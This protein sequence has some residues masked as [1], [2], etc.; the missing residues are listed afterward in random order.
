MQ[1]L[2]FY[3][4]AVN[5]IMKN[6]KV[7]L[8]SGAIIVAPEKNCLSHVEK[9]EIVDCRLVNTAATNP[10]SPSTVYVEF[11]LN[12]MKDFLIDHYELSYTL[13]NNDTNTANLVCAPYQF[14]KVEYYKDGNTLSDPIMA[15]TI[16]IENM[17]NQ[18]QTGRAIYNTNLGLSNS[19]GAYNSN[20]TIAAGANQNFRMILPAHFMHTDLLRCAIGPNLTVRI[21][22]S[23]NIITS[24]SAVSTNIAMSNLLLRC[25][26]VR[27]SSEKTK[28]MVADSKRFGLHYRSFNRYYSTYPLASVTGGQSIQVQ[29]NG[30]VGRIAGLFVMLS[31]QTRTNAN[32]PIFSP[33]TS[34]ELTDNNGQNLTNGIVLD[35]GLLLS[36]AAKIFN[37]DFFSYAGSNY[38]Y[39]I[40]FSNDFYKCYMHNIH[41]GSQ[42]FGIGDGLG[43]QL[44]VTPTNTGTNMNLIVLGYRISL[45]EV[46]NWDIREII[47]S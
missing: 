5:D 45:Y 23:S 33:I 22:P 26:G 38:V 1:N 44:K 30:Y 35:S 8:D 20:V 16:F 29:M 11:T 42:R 46:K 13:T 47:S 19:S 31:T 3:T 41:G 7:R 43:F 39:F 34:L 27:Q 32:A 12:T 6:Q 36:E 17:I 28:A 14:N 25:F 4:G 40:P 10:F 37:L 21:Y 15:D 2:D 24:G 18:P 9:K